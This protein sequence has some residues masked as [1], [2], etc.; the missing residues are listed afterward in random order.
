MD[1]C[2]DGKYA[3]VCAGSRG[4]GYSVAAALVEEGCHVLICGRSQD[5][6]DSACTSLKSVRRNGN[7]KIECVQVDLAFASGRQALIAFAQTTFPRIDILINNVGGPTPSSAFE[8]PL[9][10]WQKGF[11]Q[12]FLSAVLLSQHFARSMKAQRWGRIVTITSTSVTHPIDH[13]AVS[14]SMRSAV[15]GFMR[16]LAKELAAF[17][18]TVNCVMPGVIHTQRIEDLR[19]AK[20]Q[21]DNTTLESE[22]ERT[23][24][25]IPS[26]RLGRPDELG[27]VVAFLCSENASYITGTGLAIDGGLTI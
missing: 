1:L 13:L 9:E 24:Q 6:L 2:L 27:K 20:A 12:I 18:V 23:A 26:R 4:L 17:N 8:T 25:S 14:T 10:S 7:S 15:T 5:A 3:L 19:R 21:R 11:E 22:M 16:T